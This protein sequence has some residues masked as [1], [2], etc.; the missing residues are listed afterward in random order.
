MQRLVIVA[1]VSMCSPAAPAVA[2]SSSADAENLLRDGKQMM[3]AGKL[4]E[5]CEAFA[6]SFRKAPLAATLVNLAKCREQNH[7]YASAWGYFIE[8]ARLSGDHPGLWTEAREQAVQLESKLS[9]LIINVP[10][11]ARIEGLSITRNGVAVDIAE[12]N[13]PMPI[14]GGTYVIVGKAPAYEVWS[15]SVVVGDSYDKQS[16][17]VPRFRATSTTASPRIEARRSSTGRRKLAVGAWSL[18]VVGLG[19]GLML[20]LSA[21]GA[22]D[23][24]TE[25][26]DNVTRND[27]YD[28][29]NSKRLFATV[30]AG[31]SAALVGTGI[32]LWITGKPTLRT[33]VAV[34]LVV[35]EAHHGLAITGPL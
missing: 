15:T 2:Q 17:T 19:A 30:A 33:S 12:W 13:R 7:Q 10:N 24:A 23:E 18:G 29:A 4:A 21:R 35:G 11:E 31:A 3:V 8:A 1:L 27:R 32:V 16:V 14:D 28:A 6:G 22:Y 9:Y 34:V 26:T 25:A 20:E 5:A